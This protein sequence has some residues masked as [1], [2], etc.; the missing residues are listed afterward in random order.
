MAAA[1]S[2]DCGRTIAYRNW[3]PHARK[4]AHAL[5]AWCRDDK[6]VSMFLL[7]DR[8]VSAPCLTCGID[9]RAVHRAKMAATLPRASAS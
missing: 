5:A 4:C 6:G 3:R 1:I 8:K 9:H 2:C 7:D